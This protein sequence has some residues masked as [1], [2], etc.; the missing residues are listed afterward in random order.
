MLTAC[1]NP[2]SMSYTSLQDSGIRRQQ[3]AE[4]IKFYLKHT[5]YKIVFCNNSGYDKDLSDAVPSESGRLELIFFEGN[6][7]NK[8]FGKGYGEYNIIR[9]A[10]QNSSFLQSADYIVKIT[11]RLIINNLTRACTINLLLFCK[12]NHVHVNNEIMWDGYYDSRC[13]MAPKRFLIK[14]IDAEN[15]INDSIGYWFENDLYDKIHDSNYKAIPFLVPLQISGISGS[16]CI[17]YDNEMSCLRYI[18]HIIRSIL[19]IAKTCI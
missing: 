14:Y 18:K 12:K 7:Y 13:V 4:A 2:N 17:T 10:F 6:N 19:E 16:S 15:T 5:D 11:G 8:E 3:Y 1:I 9:Y